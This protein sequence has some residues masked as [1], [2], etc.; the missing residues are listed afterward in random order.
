MARGHMSQRDVV[1]ERAKKW[2]P[3]ADEHRYVSDDQALD[4]PSAEEL[5]NGNPAIDIDIVDASLFQG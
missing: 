1:I 5:L 3:R 2:N 4:E